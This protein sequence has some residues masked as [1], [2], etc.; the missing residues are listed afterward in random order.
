MKYGNSFR[1]TDTKDPLASAYQ[2]MNSFL[3][4]HP[5]NI[6]QATVKTDEG[7]A[8]WEVLLIKPL[9]KKGKKNDPEPL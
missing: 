8:S 5:G 9:K 4:A 7:G 6:R 1:T 2:E 3:A